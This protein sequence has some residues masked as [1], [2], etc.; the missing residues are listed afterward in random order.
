MA[1]ITPVAVVAKTVSDLQMH[2]VE[3]QHSVVTI[4]HGEEWR[5]ATFVVIHD[6]LDAEQFPI[7]P[8][9]TS[10]HFHKVDDQR[11]TTCRHCA[12]RVTHPKAAGNASSL[13][14]VCVDH[15]VPFGRSPPFESRALFSP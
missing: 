13:V 4:H 15:P 8:L 1:R 10:F 6:V 9:I 5:K 2:V 3:T 7:L 12:V 14:T 11:S